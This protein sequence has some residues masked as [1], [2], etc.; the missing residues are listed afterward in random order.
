VNHDRVSASSSRK[1]TLP[2]DRRTSRRHV[3]VS[4]MSLACASPLSPERDSSRRRGN[5]IHR[6]GRQ[7]RCFLMRSAHGIDGETFKRRVKSRVGAHVET[8]FPSTSVLSPA[9]AK[10]RK[11]RAAVGAGGR[12][13][14][15]ISPF[16]QTT[17]N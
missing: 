11:P 14:G 16:R 9:R 4:L 6:C 3:G 10:H 1:R 8:S 17:T 15:P 12:R 2:T 5:R 13:R 7:L